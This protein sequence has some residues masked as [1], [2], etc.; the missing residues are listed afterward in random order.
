MS[1]FKG[2]PICSIIR[3]T[4]KLFSYAIQ[5]EIKIQ[6]FEESGLKVIELEL[7]YEFYGKS[8]SLPWKGAI[9]SI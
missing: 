4:I 2:F 1:K 3:N 9:K 8:S 5:S 6:K 7:L